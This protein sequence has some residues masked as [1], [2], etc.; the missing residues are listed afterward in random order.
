MKVR[1]DYIEIVLCLVIFTVEKSTCSSI[2]T[3]GSR[4]L[5]TTELEAIFDQIRNGRQSQQTPVSF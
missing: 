2:Q 1:I 5:T 3:R 4:D